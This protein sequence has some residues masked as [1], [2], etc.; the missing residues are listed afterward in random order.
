MVFKCKIFHLKQKKKSSLFL[1][2]VSQFTKKISIEFQEFF[3]CLK[4]NEYFK[5]FI[6]NT[7]QTNWE[8]N[9]RNIINFKLK[10][11]RSLLKSVW[12]YIDSYYLFDINYFFFVRK[13]CIYIFFFLYFL[14]KLNL[15]FFFIFVFDH[16]FESDASG[17][18]VRS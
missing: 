18:I 16:W 10:I 14:C 2:L 8:N 9:I 5:K 1:F 11:P 13:N 7:L 6:K 12:P 4:D 15:L 3:F 17:W